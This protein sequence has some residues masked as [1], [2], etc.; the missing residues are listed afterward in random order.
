MGL[1]KV[2]GQQVQALIVQQLQL[3]G[4]LLLLEAD[5]PT[6]RLDD[7]DHAPAAHHL[8]GSLQA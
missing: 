5:D 6:P 7:K 1:G 4:E 8:L 3:G 2:E